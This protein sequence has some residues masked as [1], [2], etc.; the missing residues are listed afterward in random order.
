VPD[1]VLLHDTPVGRLALIGGEVGLVAVLW[2]TVDAHAA[3][4]P[5]DGHPVLREARRQLD[6]YFAGDL[7]R[8]TVPLEVRGTPFQRAVWAAL[9]TIPFGETRS[10]AQIARQIDR[11]SATRAVGA[12]NGRNPLS[13]VLPCHRVIGSDGTLTGFGGGLP[14]KRFLLAHEGIARQ[15]TLI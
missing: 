12:A 9:A 6:A 1:H 11:P 13:I 14:A 10:Y 5:G 2:R 15:P 7:T 3:L 8:F 4:P